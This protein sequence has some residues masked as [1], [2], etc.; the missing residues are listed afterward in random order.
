MQSDIDR[1][2]SIWDAYAQRGDR[3]VARRTISYMLVILPLIKRLEMNVIDQLLTCR[4]HMICT[5]KYS[6]MRNRCLL[7]NV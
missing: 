3:V 4:F 7:W 1:L 2:L 5:Q 6:C